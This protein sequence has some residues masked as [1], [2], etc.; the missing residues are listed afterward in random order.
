VTVRLDGRN[1]HLEGACHVEDAEPLLAM[2]QADPGRQ[3]VMS[4]AGPLHTAVVQILLHCRPIIQEGLADPFMS[5][6][7]LPLLRPQ[8]PG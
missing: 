3:V 2:I 6:W 7:L 5:R 8:T 4:K 1:I